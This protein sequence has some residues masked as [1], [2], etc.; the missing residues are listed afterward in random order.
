[1]TEFARISRRAL[2]GWHEKRQVPATTDFGDSFV[3]DVSVK[4]NDYPVYWYKH[5]ESL[6]EPYAANF[7][8]CSK[9]FT[10][11]S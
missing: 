5:E 8:E 10:E 11:R 2:K 9:R 4:N 7:A 3:F 1:V 6:L